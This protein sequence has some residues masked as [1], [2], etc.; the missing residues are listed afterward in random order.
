MYIL[1]VFQDSKRSS[2][3]TPVK[4][5]KDPPGNASSWFSKLHISVSAPGPFRDTQSLCDFSE[6]E[7][8]GVM[9]F[10]S[11]RHSS[12]V[13]EMLSKS[14]DHHLDVTRPNVNSP[15]SKSRKTGVKEMGENS[16]FHTPPENIPFHTPPEQKS[17][18]AK[19]E[20]SGQ[21]SS[22][23]CLESKDDE[24]V[25]AIN[26]SDSQ[27]ETN[28]KSDLNTK[29][30]GTGDLQQEGETTDIERE[31][32]P[33][34]QQL[35][36][37]NAMKVGEV[38]LGD[39]VDGDQD[40]LAGEFTQSLEEEDKE[41]DHESVSS[42]Q[43]S[44]IP[45]Y[46]F[47]PVSEVVT[48]DSDKLTEEVQSH[49]PV[50]SISNSN[51]GASSSAKDSKEPVS[52]SEVENSSPEYQTSS[53]DVPS[54]VGSVRSAYIPVS[55]SLFDVLVLLQRIIGFGK[56]LCQTF[57]KSTSSHR[58]NEFES[59]FSSSTTISSYFGGDMRK[60]LYTQFHEVLLNF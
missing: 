42:T 33:T 34:Q 6:A 10:S 56:T 50:T 24:D 46:D 55:G 39:R 54:S 35:L 12:S 45:S 57:Y 53:S 40:S 27:H 59:S 30:E 29:H 9:T 2:E 11:L 7:E 4:Q 14:Y 47:P 41:G 48:L 44:P 51:D 15:L 31:V 8:E 13:P 26:K 52:S 37:Q 1:Y 28:K 43:D 19:Q 58:I 18:P 32:T 3:N 23:N 22:S 25:S 49:K 20:N 36:N 21:N 60:K 38:P 16:G 5:V 17:L